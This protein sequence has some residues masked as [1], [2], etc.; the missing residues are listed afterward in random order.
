MAKSFRPIRLTS[1]LLKTM[2]EIIDYEIRSEVLK[3]APLHANYSMAKSF[4]LIRLTSFL[5]KTMEEIIDYEIRSEVLKAAPLHAK[6]H[7]YR[8]GGSTITALYQ[9]NS[10][11]QSSLDR[12]R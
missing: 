8:A 2:E 3:A 5:L 9:L 6:Q 1:F 11:I 7:S 10:E 4:R 12:A